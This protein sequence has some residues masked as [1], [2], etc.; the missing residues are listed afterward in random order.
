MPKIAYFDEGRG[1]EFCFLPFLEENKEK[2]RSLHQQ[3]KMDELKAELRRAIYE[4]CKQ[5]CA[6]FIA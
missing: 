5:E 1:S 3:G 6:D 2:Y 4:Y